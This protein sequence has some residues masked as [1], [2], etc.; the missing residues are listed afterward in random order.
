MQA[1]TTPNGADPLPTELEPGS[2]EKLALLELRLS[3]GHE[4]HHP[5]DRKKITVPIPR[6]IEG[7]RRRGRWVQDDVN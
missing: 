6:A 3:A 2:A 5:E 4:L 7:G 1:A